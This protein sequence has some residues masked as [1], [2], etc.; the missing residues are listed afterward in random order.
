MKNSMKL[1]T[2]S[3]KSLNSAMANSRQVDMEVH[4][5]QSV[6]I[7]PA[8]KQGVRHQERELTPEAGLWQA[9]SVSCS[10]PSVQSLLAM[11]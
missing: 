9:A 10:Q 11:F 3:E 4:L 2:E 7:F 6:V 8:Q 5:T 1:R